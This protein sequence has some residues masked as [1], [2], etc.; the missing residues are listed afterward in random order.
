MHDAISARPFSKQLPS[1]IP[2]HPAEHL[3]TEKRRERFPPGA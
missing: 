1:P 3:L 2:E